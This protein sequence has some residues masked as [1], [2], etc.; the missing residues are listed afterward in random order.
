MTVVIMAN[1]EGDTSKGNTYRVL[2]RFIMTYPLL[3]SVQMD[4]VVL[5]LQDMF[6]D[7]WEITSIHMPTSSYIVQKKADLRIRPKSKPYYSQSGPTSYLQTYVFSVFPVADPPTLP[8]H[9]SYKFSS[10]SPVFVPRPAPAP[11]HIEY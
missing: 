3:S 9:K 5:T 10:S 2:M 4:A 7:K 11:L 1:P 6:G 8:F